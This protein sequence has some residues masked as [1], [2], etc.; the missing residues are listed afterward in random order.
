MTGQTRK[1][2]ELLGIALLLVVIACIFIEYIVPLVWPFIL[3]YGLA[4]L[5][6][7][8]VR[9][10]KNKLHF[11]KNAATGLT[12][13]FAIGGIAVAFYFLI[14]AVITQIMA[15]VNEWPRYQS[16]FFRYLRNICG[17]MEDSL[18]MDEGVVYKRVCDGVDR[19][20]VS[21]EERIMP[22]VMN[23]SLQTL[24]VLMDVVIVVALT[25]MAVFYMARDMEK[26]R[27]IN[28][29]N[30]FY[31]ELMYI[32]GLI[33]R[34]LRAY[35]RSQ[36]I[37]MS[38][39]AAICAMGLAIIGNKYNIVLGI[40][41]GI[42]DALPLIGAGTVLI[43]WSVIYIFMGEYVKAA[44]LF[45]IFIICYL[46]REFLEPRLMG[47]KIGMT[48]IATLISIYI[49]YQ[50]FGFVGMI[51]GPLVYV[52]IREILEKINEGGN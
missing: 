38:I 39:V 46:A 5:I 34:I 28:T 3:A 11:H 47:Q 15:F 25:V 18:H 42:F 22:L 21:F 52:M 36:A 6:S 9:F 43:P 30:I 12:L 13:V 37:I 51:A 49:G 19:F 16:E 14:D 4:I 31:N 1:K 44:I 27:K 48:P 26:I 17:V 33:S 24:L 23:N 32:K 40:I 29:N 45:V 41:I 20:V 7:P 8:I 35:V 2:L 10:L 50:L